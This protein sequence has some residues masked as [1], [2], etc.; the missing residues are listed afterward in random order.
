M[1]PD[2][3]CQSRSAPYMK[4]AHGLNRMRYICFLLLDF[5]C[6]YNVVLFIT[7]SFVSL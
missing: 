1:Y 6:I 4:R 3:V 5:G 7:L 2:L